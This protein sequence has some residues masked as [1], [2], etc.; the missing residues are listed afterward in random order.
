M[1]AAASFELASAVTRRAP[2]RYA[3]T[4]DESWYQGRGAYGGLVAALLGRALEAEVGTDRAARTLSVGFCAPATAGAVEVE[5][6]IERAGR[7]V[8]QATARMARGDATIATAIATFARSR[9][10]ETDWNAAPMPP[11]P[12]P[13][14]VPDGPEALYIPAF[15]RHLELRQALGP[16]PFTGGADA[17]VGGYCRFATPTAPD[18][19]TV[20]GLVDAW[21][22]AV[23]GLR[24]AWSPAASVDMTITLLAPLPL[25]PVDHAW[26]AFDARCGRAADGYAD[27]TATLWTSDGRPIARVQQLIAIF[28]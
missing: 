15:C 2:G 17:R 18:L 26:Y 9:A 6:R 12:P 21:P 14:E 28:G 5:V 4:L 23:L 20:A 7:N 16:A 25:G 10:S 8:T 11:M 22:P 27:E 24:P 19:A 3:A 1:S 13:D